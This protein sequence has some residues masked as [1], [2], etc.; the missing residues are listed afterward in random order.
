MRWIAAAASLVLIGVGA[1]AQAE[2][3]APVE[4]ACE[5]ASR[6]ELEAGRPVRCEVALDLRGEPLGPRPEPEVVKVPRRA[7]TG[8]ASPQVVEPEAPKALGVWS[9]T[10][11]LRAQAEAQAPA[12][13]RPDA[14]DAVFPKAP[15]KVR[16]GA[17]PLVEELASAPCAEHG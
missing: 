12:C 5:P 10:A 17:L 7:A 11:V 3:A 9:G 16:R 8:G 2:T 1:E 14:G 15:I 13:G 4:I 6:A